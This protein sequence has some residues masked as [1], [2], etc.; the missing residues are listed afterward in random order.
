MKKKIYLLLAVCLYGLVVCADPI[1]KQQAQQIAAGWLKEHVQ[2]CQGVRE[3]P[4]RWSQLRR[5]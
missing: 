5:R 3:L 4:L 1:S 2:K